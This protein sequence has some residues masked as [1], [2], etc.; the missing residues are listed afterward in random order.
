[1]S[2]YEKDS[3]KTPILDLCRR[4]ILYFSFEEGQN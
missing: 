2:E 3:V 1:M 4:K